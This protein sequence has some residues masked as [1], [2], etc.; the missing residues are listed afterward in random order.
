MLNDIC[1]WYSITQCSVS[2]TLDLALR[3]DLTG[4][5]IDVGLRGFLIHS[6]LMS[7]VYSKFCIDSQNEHYFMRVLTLCQLPGAKQ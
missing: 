6:N 1:K 4:K 2:K 7:V 3:K 5:V